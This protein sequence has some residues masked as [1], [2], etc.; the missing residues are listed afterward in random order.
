MYLRGLPFTVL[1]SLVL[2]GFGFDELALRGVPALVALPRVAIAFWLARAVLPR[3][4]A[5]VA[6]ALVAVAPLD[7]ELSRTARMYSLFMT[8]DGLFLVGAMELARTGRGA[9]RASTWGAL[10]L[11]THSLTA[12]HAPLPLLALFRRAVP[13]DGRPGGFARLALRV[14]AVTGALAGVYLAYD[15]LLTSA[16]SVM[17]GEQPPGRP[18]P[19]G[20]HLAS[21]RAVTTGPGA[22]VAGL[23][24]LSGLALAVQG[25]RR[26]GS[27]V[28]GLL[29][30][31]AAVTFAAA[32]PVL[33]T[34]ALLAALAWGAIGPFEAPLRAPRLLLAAAL[35]TLGW[36]MA[37]ALAPAGA[38]PADRA[39]AAGRLLLSL[40]APNWVEPV[41][42]APA[43]AAL[44]AAGI[45]VAFERAARDPTPGTWFLLVAA[46][47]APALLGGLVARKEALR[48]QAHALLPALV[49]AV[50]ALR[51]AAGR[52]GLRGGAAAATALLLAG[53]AVRPDLA[54]Q[55]ALRRHGPVA[56]PFAVLPVAPDHRGA[57][58][59]LAARARPGEPV[60]A[61]DP[62]QMHVYLGRADYWLRR[63]DDAA[64]FVTRHPDGSL[65]DVYVGARL[66]PE[67]G[68]LRR[69][70][71][72]R[73]T[74]TAWLVT[75][76]EVEVAPEWYRTPA[77]R[78]TLEAWRPLAW[79]LGEDGLTRI[80]R[81]EDGRP[82]PPP[83]PGSEP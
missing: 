62:L 37:A 30:V 46:A 83:P 78:S 5:L 29:A 14:A 71:A 68:E 10:S 4:F 25:A 69:L 52:V 74:R 45:L 20:A 12:L 31:A 17:G 67:V 81:L 80:Y 44:V 48:Y 13:A 58:R 2:G 6:A 64:A 9:L 66:V 54:L 33:G 73:G 32:A 61:E 79:F 16:Y 11:V 77:T 75:S 8:L 65:R 3:G 26:L 63:F 1:E 70:L 60:V 41:L 59:F 7:V 34:P 49:L 42:A 28:A 53:A 82:V 57:A 76:G 24:A 43:L 38:A 72:E 22:A 18:S 39:A 23:G 40:P 27:G 21:L 51:W 47:L 36:G 35:P 19:L 56:S 15:A 50:V 55:A